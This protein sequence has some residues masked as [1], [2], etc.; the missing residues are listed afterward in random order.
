M[1]MTMDLLM[2]T[3]PELLEMD[4]LIKIRDWAGMP[5]AVLNAI[6]QD[7]GVDEAVHLRVLAAV[8]PDAMRLALGK[9]VVATTTVDRKLT[10]ME[11]GF[12]N[13]VYNVVRMRFQAPLSDLTTVPAMAMQFPP[14]PPPTVAPV[15]SVAIKIKICNTLNQGSDMEVEQLPAVELMEMRRRFNTLMGDN[16]PAHQQVS[17]R[18]LSALSIVVAAGIGPF[19][20]MG[21]W[22][23]HGPRVERA[24]KFKNFIPDGEGG[25][26]MCE[27]PGAPDLDT[28]LRCWAIFRT[29]A[30]MTKLADSAT[31]D[32]YADQFAKK[33][34]G[35]PGVLAHLCS[36]R[37]YL[38][39]RAVA[40]TTS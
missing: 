34:S 23:P 38:Q 11:L 29:A 18:Q 12:M 19:V 1:A 40:G 4:T 20:D 30:I 3:G 17:D 28:W 37:H 36:S 7:F 22:Q 35:V 5:P 31:L 15:K 25:Q 2:P 39:D 13:L 6:L 16:P 8:S 14:M 32:R 26:R 10:V 24:Q 27:M 33:L 9:I 21:V